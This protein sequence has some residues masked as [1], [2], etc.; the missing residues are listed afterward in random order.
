VTVRCQEC[1]RRGEWPQ[2]E[3][4]CPCGTVLRI[5]V[6]PVTIRTAHDAVTAAALQLKSLG[7]HDLVQP[8]VRP[9]SGVDL[10]GTGVVA[11]VDPS[12]RPTTLREVECL[13]LN[14]LNASAASVFFSLTGYADDARARADSLGIPLFVVDLAGSPQPVNEAADVLIAN[15]SGNGNSNSNGA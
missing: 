1:G 2:P 5:P 10:C 8:E 11:R 15:A 12:T 13:W 14:G 7:F 9:A 3:L 4:G 6:R